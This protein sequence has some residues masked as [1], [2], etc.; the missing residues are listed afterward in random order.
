ML[1]YLTPI[2]SVGFSDVAEIEQDTCNILLLDDDKKL[3]WHLDY[4]FGG[5]RLGSILDIYNS[6]YCKKSLLDHE[7]NFN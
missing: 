5:W 1:I 3:Y 6:N 2:H 4:L 7:T